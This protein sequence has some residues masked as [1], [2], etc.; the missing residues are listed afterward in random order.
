MRDLLETWR[1]A[2]GLLEEAETVDGV[3]AQRAEPSVLDVMLPPAY[4]HLVDGKLSDAPE[5]NALVGIA[6]HYLCDSQ[7][8]WRER[9]FGRD[10]WADPFADWQGSFANKLDKRS[11]KWAFESILGE[12]IQIEKIKLAYCN[13]IPSIREITF[14]GR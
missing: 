7:G 9:W 4:K 13:N 12:V 1:Q 14:K 3:I 10:S 8:N 2:K 5:G 6:R 11:K